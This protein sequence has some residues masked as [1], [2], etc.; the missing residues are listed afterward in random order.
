MT[1]NRTNKNKKN[2]NKQKGGDSLMFGFGII[3]L[4][5][6]LFGG[7]FIKLKNKKNQSVPDKNNINQRQSRITL[8]QNNQNKLL[9][10][11]SR[12][13]SFNRSNQSSSR[14]SDKKKTFVFESSKSVSEPLIPKSNSSNPVSIPKPKD[15]TSVTF[16]KST[17]NS[18]K[19]LSSVESLSASELKKGSDDINRAIKAGIRQKNYRDMSGKSIV[20]T[21]KK[22]RKKQEKEKRKQEKTEKKQM[23]SKKK[24]T[25]FG[26]TRKR[27][28]KIQRRKRRQ[29]INRTYKK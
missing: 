11:R 13:N 27:K 3:S 4:L 16:N 2:K 14:K 8:S 20:K 23:Q 6:L 12:S 5:A 9:P 21:E 10:E 26:G 25:F 7:A 19:S 29:R 15:E 1:K 17:S 22:L 24:I 28:Q 18:N